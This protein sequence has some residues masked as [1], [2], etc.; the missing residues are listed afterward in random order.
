MCTS[1]QTHT[2][3]HTADSTQKGPAA[4]SCEPAS[5][6]VPHPLFHPF[7]PFACHLFLRPLQT[8]SLFRSK[9][10][11]GLSLRGT[12]RELGAEDGVGNQ[13]DLFTS[14]LTLVLL[15][16]LGE[17]EHKGL[18]KGLSGNKHWKLHKEHLGL[19]DGWKTLAWYGTVWCGVVWLALQS[20]T[21]P[22]PP[23]P[24][25]GP[26]WE[27][28]LFR[29]GRR[30]NEWMSKSSGGPLQ[31]RLFVYTSQ[32]RHTSLAAQPTDNLWCPNRRWVCGCS[33]AL[34]L[35]GSG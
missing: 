24:L 16:M 17:F 25:W 7:H 34:S 32:S 33:S 26:S 30:T 8:V 10:S 14:S 12:K 22:L 28:P 23:V 6:D 31:W 27:G 35:S 4:S 5:S 3:T 15:R 20:E 29:A 2:T 9:Q 19:R 18:R 11:C 1:R 21:I 13:A